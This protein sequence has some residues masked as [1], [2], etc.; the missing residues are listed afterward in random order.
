MVSLQWIAE[1]ARND[2]KDIQIDVKKFRASSKI[3]YA[4]LKTFG[5]C[6]KFV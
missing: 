5:D 2:G 1:Q 4:T 3:F 6:A